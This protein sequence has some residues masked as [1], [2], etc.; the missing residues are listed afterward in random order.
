MGVPTPDKRKGRPRKDEP[1][2]EEAE[3]EVQQ[4]RGEQKRQAGEPVEDVRERIRQSE[5]RQGRRG[6]QGS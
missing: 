3:G 6:R 5:P 2:L 4:K 1:L